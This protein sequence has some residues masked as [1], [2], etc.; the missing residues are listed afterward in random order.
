[1]RLRTEDAAVVLLAYAVECPQCAGG[2]WYMARQ[3]RKGRW[4]YRWRPM[5]CSRCGYARRLAE[6]LTNSEPQPPEVV[7]I[8]HRDTD[9]VAEAIA[10]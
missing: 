9:W 8:G 2:G 5:R 3:K 1:M 6:A 4:Y 10:R 7:S